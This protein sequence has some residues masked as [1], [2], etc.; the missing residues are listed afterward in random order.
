MV[1]KDPFSFWLAYT[2]QKAKDAAQALRDSDLAGFNQN[3]V[4][5]DPAGAS[6]ESHAFVRP[7]FMMMDGDHNWRRDSRTAFSDNYRVFKQNPALS[8]A[9]AFQFADLTPGTYA[10][11]ASWL[12]NV[13]LAPATN[14]LYRLY[15][16][17]DNVISFIDKNG[18]LVDSVRMDQKQ[19][20]TEDSAGGFDFTTIGSV[21]VTGTVLKLVIST[22]GADG[23]VIAG[24]VRIVSA[25][26]GSSQVAAIER[27]SDSTVKTSGTP[28][29]EGSGWTEVSY[30]AGSG[31][32][33]LWKASSFVPHSA[34]SSR[35]GSTRT[36]R[37]LISGMP[38]RLIRTVRSS[39]NTLPDRM[40]RLRPRS[41]LNRIPASISS[42]PENRSLRIPIRSSIPIFGVS[43]STQD[44]LTLNVAGTIEFCG[45]ISGLSG[46]HL[47]GSGTIILDEGVRITIDGDLTIDLLDTGTFESIHG[48]TGLTVTDVSNCVEIRS[49]ATV[50][51]NSISITH[52]P[53]PPARR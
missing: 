5:L 31:N 27:N 6:G 14:V 2:Y 29:S 8:S 28:Y 25:D 53:E 10:V 30:A 51:A 22:E 36:T 52:A 15:D 11:Q 12:S 17:N 32:F 34:R 26:N 19:F 1:V 40:Q 41:L 38:H 23:D 9:A 33:V 24:P 49:G 50:Q 37:S 44:F 4:A 48:I 43:D 46:L 7:W 13:L 16:E 47:I 39:R 18:N 21:T 35:T 42:S 45:T 20:P 3:V